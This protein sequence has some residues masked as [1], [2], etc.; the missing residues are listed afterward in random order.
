[1]FL[2]KR[3]GMNSVKAV[4]PVIKK[5]TTYISIWTMAL[6][7]IMQGVIFFMG[8]WNS[9]VL[10]GNLLGGAAAVL[11]FCLMCKGILAAV[12]KDEQDAKTMI[13][14]SRT[15]RMFMLLAI[16][17]VGAVLPVFNT[18]AVLISL[19]FPRIAIIFWPIFNKNKDKAEGESKNE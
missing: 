15:L 1:M 5:E 11:N 2:D 9:G 16:A 4:N 18:W 8:K 3:K 6:S 7:L 13:R 10:L 19:F 14:M 17:A 12:E